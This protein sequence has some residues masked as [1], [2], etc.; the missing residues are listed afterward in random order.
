M[1]EGGISSAEQDPTHSGRILE[2]SYMPGP[3]FGAIRHTNF[4]PYVVGLLIGLS[5]IPL[6]SAAGWGFAVAAVGLAALSLYGTVRQERE[7]HKVRQWNRVLEAELARSRKLA[8]L[9]DLSAGIA[10]EINNPLGIIAQEIQWMQHVLESD[11]FKGLSGT[12]ECRDSLRVISLQVNRCKEIVEKLVGMAKEMQPVIQRIDVNEVVG[13]IADLVVKEASAKGIHI[14]KVFESNLPHAHS[15]PPLL[16]QVI[17]NLMVNAMQAIG[18]DGVI[19]I[20]TSILEKD[21]IA[22]SIEDNGCGIP[23][24][25]LDRIFIPFFSTKS[26]GKGTGMGLAICRGIIERLGGTLSVESEVG[27]YTIFT[28]SLPVEGPREGALR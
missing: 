28:I 26:E 3:A 2:D 4:R 8:S 7:V 5:A 17:L 1:A 15:D 19:S 25:N 10:H 20:R 12:E 27:R 11:S 13:A 6:W 24:E 22:I 18:Q 21:F 23:R 14:E 9:N 16:R